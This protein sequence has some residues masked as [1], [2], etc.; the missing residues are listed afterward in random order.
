MQGK[1][2]CVELVGRILLSVIA[3]DLSV[4]LSVVIG[5]LFVLKMCISFSRT[6]Q[7]KP[8]SS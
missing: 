2:F 3:Y 1:L 4:L 6:L 8:T 7:T 5:R